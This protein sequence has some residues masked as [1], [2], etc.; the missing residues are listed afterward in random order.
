MQAL[1]RRDDRQAQR[2]TVG[3]SVLKNLF[4]NDGTVQCSWSHA[5]VCRA[6]ARPSQWRTHLRD[7]RSYCDVLGVV[8]GCTA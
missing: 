5:M 3:Y 8:I 2:H 4:P 7:W 1:S 6:G